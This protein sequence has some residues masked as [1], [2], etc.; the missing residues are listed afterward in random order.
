MSD[1]VDENTETNANKCP[2]GKQRSNSQGR[3][4]G[5]GNGNG[6]VGQPGGPGGR[7]RRQGQSSVRHDRAPGTDRHPGDPVAGAG[8]HAPETRSPAAAPGRR[9]RPRVRGAPRCTPHQ[10][11]RLQG[12]RGAG[13]SVPVWAKRGRWHYREIS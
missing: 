12:H 3:G 4:L 9:H 11:A 7:S 10:A 8:G 13:Q 2:G 6:P 1:K 5:R